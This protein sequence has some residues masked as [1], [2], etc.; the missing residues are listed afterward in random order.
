MSK[1]ELSVEDKLKMNDMI[2]GL[3][4]KLEKIRT[5]ATNSFEFPEVDIS[6][7]VEFIKGELDDMISKISDIGYDLN[8][9]RRST[10]RVRAGAART[11][12]RNRKN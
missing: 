6:T 5:I 11:A 9:H 10:K 7:H 4:V 8:R 1:I 3:H 12:R 2:G